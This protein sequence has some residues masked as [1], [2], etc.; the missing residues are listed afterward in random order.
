MKRRQERR[1]AVYR[2]CRNGRA[3]FSIFHGGDAAGNGEND[4]EQK[5]MS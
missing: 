3:T 4:A 5:M 1:E 2:L